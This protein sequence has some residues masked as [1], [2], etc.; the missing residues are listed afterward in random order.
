M[1]NDY[2]AILLSKIEKLNLAIYDINYHSKQL[3]TEIWDVKDCNLRVF[4]LASQE[5]NV[6]YNVSFLPHYQWK[7]VCHDCVWYDEYLGRKYDKLTMVHIFAYA[8][9]P[10]LKVYSLNLSPS[11]NVINK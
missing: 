2:S 11:F 5:K 9:R 3:Y 6:P 7:S 10:Y 1:Q 8:Q 4:L